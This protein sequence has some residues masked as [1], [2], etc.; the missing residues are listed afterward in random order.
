LQAFL[1]TLA[2]DFFTC[3]KIL[4]HGA[5]GFTSH[6]KGR[7]LWIFIGLKNPSPWPASNPWLYGPVASTLT[8]TS[9]RRLDIH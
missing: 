3:C 5:S 6:P 2:S 7:V 8:T 9:Q 4:W 1:F